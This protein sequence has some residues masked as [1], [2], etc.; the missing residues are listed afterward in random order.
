MGPASRFC[1]FVCVVLA[2][3]D[4][5]SAESQFMHRI[6]PTAPSVAPSKQ[7][8]STATTNT[9]TPSPPP[10]PHP[11]DLRPGSGNLVEPVPAKKI[12][13]MKQA[14][15]LDPES[16]E[17]LV[18]AGNK[19][20]RRLMIGFVGSFEVF[21]NCSARIK[22]RTKD[23][24]ESYKVAIRSLDSENSHVHF[25]SLTEYRA[26]FLCA[27]NQDCIISDKRER[28]S[29]LRVYTNENFD[30]PVILSEMVSL[31]RNL[32]V[33]I[34]EEKTPTPHELNGGTSAVA[35]PVRLP[36]LQP[37]PKPGFKDHACFKGN[38]GWV[39]C[40]VTNR[41]VECEQGS[42]DFADPISQSIYLI[43]ECIK[44]EEPSVTIINGENYLDKKS[45]IFMGNEPG[46][47][48]GF[49]GRLKDGQ[50]LNCNA[51][52]RGGVAMQVETFVQRGTSSSLY[53]D[54]TD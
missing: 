11:N 31:C 40:N 35:G 36:P 21:P 45:E 15:S 34:L 48:I 1:V 28:A 17:K 42:P 30:I 25:E 43:T 44:R 38:V 22:L 23:G 20:N 13:E 3:S 12:P 33:P 39:T 5:A 46:I 4:A 41:K 37:E 29:A 51:G 2:F 7:P 9:Q 54:L 49:S 10:A 6:D 50:W 8:E 26:Y 16:F 24:Y 53:C 47:S 27:N 32:P 52:T 19:I 14:P 18:A